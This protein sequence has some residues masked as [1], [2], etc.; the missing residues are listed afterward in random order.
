M[1][2]PFG[3]AARRITTQ[4][5]H[6]LYPGRADLVEDRDELLAGAPDA[7]EVCHRLDSQVALEPP[8]H[9][10]RAVARRATGAVGHR[11]EVRLERA[12]RF[13]RGAEIP[14]PVVGLRREELEGEDRLFSGGEDLVDTHGAR[15]YNLDTVVARLL[16]LSATGSPAPPALA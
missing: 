8:G 4:R 2:L 16:N 7:A 14:L 6:V 1:G 5:E 13:E 3:L 11:D 12:E 9:L 10:Q 15:L